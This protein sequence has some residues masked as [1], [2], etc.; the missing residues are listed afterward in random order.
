MSVPLIAAIVSFVG[1]FAAWVVLP[2]F[3]KKHHDNKEEE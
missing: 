1:L 3:L 2:S